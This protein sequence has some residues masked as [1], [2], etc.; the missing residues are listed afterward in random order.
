MIQLALRSSTQA[1]ARRR[2]GEVRQDRGQR[3]GRDHQLEA[4]QEHAGAEDGEQHE[5]GAAIHPGEC[6]GRVGSRPRAPTRGARQLGGAATM[7]KSVIRTTGCPAASNP[8]Q[9]A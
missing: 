9:D 6:I 4:G 3:D 2:I 1:D 8:N 7:P 5:R